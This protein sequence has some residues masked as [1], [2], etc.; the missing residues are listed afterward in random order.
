MIGPLLLLVLGAAL[1][2]SAG[3]VGVAAA[4]VS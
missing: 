4:A 1:A 2:A 3:A